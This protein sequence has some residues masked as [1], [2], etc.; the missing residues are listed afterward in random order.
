M[1]HDQSTAQADRCCHH[2]GIDGHFATGADAC[3][4]VAGDACSS[5]TGRDHP[6]IAALQFTVNRLVS[7]RATVEFDQDHGGDS[8]WFTALLCRPHGGSDSFVPAC[9]RFRARQRRERFCIE[10]QGHSAS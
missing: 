10:D 4:R 8:Y 6:G 3:Q 7:P 1:C 9:G 5:C 2:E